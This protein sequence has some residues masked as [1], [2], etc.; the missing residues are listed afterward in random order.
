[1]T[2]IQN[3]TDKPIAVI[4]LTT[5]IA[6]NY[7]SHPLLKMYLESRYLIGKNHLQDQ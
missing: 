4:I 6:L 1:M 7:I 3:S 2:W 5:E